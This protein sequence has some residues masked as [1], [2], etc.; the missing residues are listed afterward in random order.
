MTD[1]NRT[2][3]HGL[4]AVNATERATTDVIARAVRLC[5]RRHL[6]EGVRAI[7]HFR[8][9]DREERRAH[10]GRYG[11]SMWPQGAFLPWDRATPVAERRPCRLLRSRSR[12]LCAP[13]GHDFISK[14][15]QCPKAPEVRSVP[16][17][18]FMTDSIALTPRPSVEAHAT[19]PWGRADHFPSRHGL[20]EHCLSRSLGGKGA[21]AKTTCLIAP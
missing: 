3:R 13:S 18:W 19:T 7:V 20:H 16:P 4:W 2:V 6:F 9:V 11:C 1:L 8:L 17:T 10:I 5:G 12:V 15:L 21:L 14:G